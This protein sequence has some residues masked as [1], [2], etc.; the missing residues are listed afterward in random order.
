MAVADATITV[1]IRRPWVVRYGGVVVV[2]ADRI[3]HRFG[4]FAMDKL[5]RLAKVEV[6]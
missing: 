6:R 2:A 1:R 4:D 3:S 5:L